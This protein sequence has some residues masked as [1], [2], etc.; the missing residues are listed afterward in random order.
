MI[1]AFT[2]PK[3]T[4]LP[5]AIELKFVPL[6]VT[7]VPTGPETGLIEVIV[8]APKLKPASVAVPFGVVTDTLPLDP[9]PTV[10]VIVVD[11]LMIK[12]AAVVA[13]NFTCVVPVKLVPVIV[14]T[15]PATPTIGLNEEIVGPLKI[16]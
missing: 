1:V 5:G 4:V 10:A 7:I 14:T 11:E 13:P 8:G 16:N 2:A 15:V 9:A 12:D 6:I 3:K